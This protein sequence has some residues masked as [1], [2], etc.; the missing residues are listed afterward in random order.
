MAGFPYELFAMVHAKSV[1]EVRTLV[2]EVAEELHVANYDVLFSTAEYKK[3]SMQYFMEP[4][5]R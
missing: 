1:E 2:A 4:P 5:E 3:Q